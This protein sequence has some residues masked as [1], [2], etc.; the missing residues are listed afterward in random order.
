M[1]EDLITLLIDDDRDDRDFFS[2]VMKA[3]DPYIRCRFASDGVQALRQLNE[4]TEMVPDII[5]MD[6]NM[7]KMNGIEEVTETAKYP[8]LYLFDILRGFHA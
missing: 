7:P 6:I 3:A 5:F 4:D 8:H 2:M 1:S